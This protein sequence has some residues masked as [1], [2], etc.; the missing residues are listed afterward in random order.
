MSMKYSLDL[1]AFDSCVAYIPDDAELCEFTS[2]YVGDAK[3]VLYCTDSKG[4]YDSKMIADEIIHIPT[5]HISIGSRG[6]M[7]NQ[8]VR[9]NILAAIGMEII[10]VL[11]DMVVWHDLPVSLD[12]IVIPVKEIVI[13][14]N[15]EKNTVLGWA[16]V[17]IAYFVPKTEVETI[18]E[19]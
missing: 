19:K 17:G 10:R 18:K 14:G 4:S 2:D 15:S 9:D 12:N 6:D 3:E 16:E 5:F 1:G 11:S 7:T 8:I 13:T